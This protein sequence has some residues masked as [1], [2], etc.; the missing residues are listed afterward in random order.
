MESKPT[1]APIEMEFIIDDPV[2]KAAGYF[3]QLPLAVLEDLKLSDGAKLTYALIL[4]YAWGKSVV[5]PSQSTMAER[6]G[7]SDRTIRRHLNELEDNK[8]I[9]IE[10]RGLNETNM[11]HLLK[12]P[13]SWD[14]KN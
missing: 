13:V 12:L 5:W 4:S 2:L 7:I 1:P 9:K 6:R 11:C 8:Y 10:Q 14:K 3:V